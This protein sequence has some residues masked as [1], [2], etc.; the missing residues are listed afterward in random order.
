MN[1]FLFPPGGSGPKIHMVDYVNG[2]SAHALQNG[3]RFSNEKKLPCKKTP[4]YIICHVD[5]WPLSPRGEQKNSELN[6]CFF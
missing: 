5:F 4:M 2:C 1:F 3:C 6:V